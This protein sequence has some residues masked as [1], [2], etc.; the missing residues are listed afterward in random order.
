MLEKQENF[1]R[2]LNCLRKARGLS[3]VEFSK[4]LDIPKTT[5]QSIRQTT[6]HTAIRIAEKLAIPLD[7]MANGSLSTDE[8]KLL[9]AFLLELDW[10]SRLSKE[11]QEKALEHLY[12]LLLL[13]QEG[14][15]E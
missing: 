2:N 3:M 15:H 6:F 4:E 11:K 5:L 8:I 12:A 14:R 10:F 9:E 1:A 13:V 7:T